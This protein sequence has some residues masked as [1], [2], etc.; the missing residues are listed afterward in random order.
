MLSQRISRTSADLDAPWRHIPRFQ[1]YDPAEHPNGVISFATAENASLPSSNGCIKLIFRI[2]P[3][4]PKSL[5][6]L[7]TP[8][9]V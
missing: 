4:L 8:V 7:Q 5:N 1:K 3:L 2:R 9:L 6:S